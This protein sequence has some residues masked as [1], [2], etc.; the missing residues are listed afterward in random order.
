[1]QG[2]YSNALAEQQIEHLIN[3]VTENKSKARIRSCGGTG[4]GDFLM[5]T[6]TSPDHT[7]DNLEFKT[8]LRWR[9]GL[10][11]H[12]SGMVCARHT[13]KKGPC[14]SLMEETG[15]HAV[16]CNAGGINIK[17]RNWLRDLLA[18]ACACAKLHTLTE[19]Y[20]P[21]LTKWTKKSR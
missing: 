3:I 18:H 11:I 16:I 7:F 14:N 6:P 15:E 4:G 12:S 10:P 5:V 21:E 13:L 1:M 19:Q 9:L 17:R 20:I 2:K 8:S